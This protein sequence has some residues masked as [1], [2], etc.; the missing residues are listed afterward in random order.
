MSSKNLLKRMEE[1]GV[2]TEALSE[3]INQSR[4]KTEQKLKGKVSWRLNAEMKVI[5]DHFNSLGASENIQSL[6]W[7][8]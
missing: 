6:F 7:D 3:I 4:G 2:T 1:Y 8:D 5:V